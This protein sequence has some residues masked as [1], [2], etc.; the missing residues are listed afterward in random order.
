[1]H[2]YYMRQAL[3]IAEY[4]IGRTSPNPLVGAV[5]VRDGRIV[6][7]G[8]HRQAGTPHAEIHALNQAGELARGATM[9]VTLEPCSHY[10]LTG[11]CTE[12][13]IAAGIR[14]VVAAMTDP[15][16]EVAGNGFKKL[17]EAGIEVI[18]GVFAE[19][20]A[21]QNEVFLKWITTGMPFTVLKTATTLDGKIATVAGQSQWIT[22]PEARNFVHMLR[23][24]YDAIVTGIGTVI[25]DNP[26][27]TTRLPQGGKNPVR[28]IV[29]SMGRTPPDANVVSDGQARTIIAVSRDAPRQKLELLARHGAEIWELDRANGGL[30]LRALFRRL[31]KDRLTGVLVEAGAALNASLFN[32]NLVD[33][34]HWFV[35]PQIVGGHSAPGP[36]GGAGIAALSGAITLEDVETGMVGKDLLITAYIARREGRDVYRACGRIGQS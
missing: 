5:I 28:V 23:D 21:R 30:D 6:G 7:Q 18:E 33:K 34:V 25:A 20:A 11:P 4:A 35:S 29:D 14:Q 1:M 27:L 15:N 19:A 22:G 36:V 12:A 9:Y 32:D 13:I 8:W 26:Q 2:E 31:G 17:R 24:R 16:P 3:T 10:G